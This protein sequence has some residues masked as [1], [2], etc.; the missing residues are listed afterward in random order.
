MKHT[1]GNG[2]AQC[3]GGGLGLD[4]H[5]IIDG[6][7]FVNSDGDDS[8]VVS[9][10]Y[11]GDGYWE[12]TASKGAQSN[13]EIA[14]SWFSGIFAAQTFGQSTKDT[15]FLVHGNSFGSAPEY[16]LEDN[17]VIKV[18]DWNNEIRTN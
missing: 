10:H 2:Y 12:G 5:I 1:R 6:C 4:G 13:V 18:T 8:A 17:P 11:S 3:I 14:N 16:P 15:N 7:K 9:Y